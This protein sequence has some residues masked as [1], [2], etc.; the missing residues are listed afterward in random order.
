MEDAQDTI[1]ELLD[2]AKNLIGGRRLDLESTLAM[3]NALPEDIGDKA[4]SSVEQALQAVAAAVDQDSRYEA[5][6]R[7]A[8]ARV[9]VMLE[10]HLAELHA[11][12]RPKAPAIPV[13]VSTT[14]RSSR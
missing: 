1:A 2:I 12:K 11:A 3:L 5:V 4:Q 14:I 9:I 7:F 8:L 13:V 6:A 10:T